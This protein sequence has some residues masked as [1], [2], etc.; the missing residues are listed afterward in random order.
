MMS[1][2]SPGEML[3]MPD[4]QWNKAIETIVEVLEVYAHTIAVVVQRYSV[5]DYLEEVPWSSDMCYS[6]KPNI[7]EV[8]EDIG[9]DEEED[10]DEDIG[11]DEEDKEDEENVDTNV[12]IAA[13]RG[14]GDTRSFEA[15]RVMSFYGWSQLIDSKF[16]E[17]GAKGFSY[18]RCAYPQ[19]V[20]EAL[21][22]RLG[23]LVK[24]QYGLDVEFSLEQD[25]DCSPATVKLSSSFMAP[26][27]E[28]TWLVT[29]EN[30]YGEF[31]VLGTFKEFNRKTVFDS[32]VKERKCPA[33]CVK[34]FRLA[35]DE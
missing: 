11:E 29:V 16:Y 19:D 13:V 3:I 18:A 30:F 25:W 28:Y 34:L 35:D 22:Q 24:D 31:V 10:V 15:R 9:E 12:T 26:L 1:V 6:V 21:V 33:R 23:E 17:A 7:S 2:K 27:T 5:P 14:Q 32:I 4:E 20:D 8:D